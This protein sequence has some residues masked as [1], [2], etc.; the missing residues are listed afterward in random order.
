MLGVRGG[1]TREHRDAI[2]V[3]LRTGVFRLGTGSFDP[4]TLSG[5][6][7]VRRHT[8]LQAPSEVRPILHPSPG[9][10]TP[11]EPHGTTS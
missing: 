10:R 11:R 9:A 4:V 6:R 2:C 7:A 3:R 8:R 1:S 5:R